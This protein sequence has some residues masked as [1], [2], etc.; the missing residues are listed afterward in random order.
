MEAVQHEEALGVVKDISPVQYRF[1]TEKVDLDPLY[2]PLRDSLS[3]YER[4][5]HTT[6]KL[7]DDLLP[8]DGNVCYSEN[9]IVDIEAIAKKIGIEIIYESPE[10]QKELRNKHAVLRKKR[11]GYQVLV[12]KEAS[13]EEQ[14]F[15]I[16][17]E[18]GHY[19]IKRLVGQSISS[20][21]NRGLSVT[22]KISR[23]ARIR[24]VDDG[25]QDQEIIAAR[26]TSA[27]I[28][29]FFNKGKRF[30]IG[31]FVRNSSFLNSWLLAKVY[32]KL[33]KKPVSIWKIYDTMHKNTE[34]TTKIEKAFR[35][36]LAYV[37]EEEKADYFAANILVPTERFVLWRSKSDNKIAKAFGVPKKC[38]LKRRKYEIKH[39]LD[40]MSREYL[41][42]DVEIEISAPSTPK[43]MKHVLGGHSIHDI[44]RD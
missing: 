27:S 35:K 8:Y 12:N 25:R 32:R 39:E 4:L 42:S 26:V 15:S 6:K 22:R 34:A 24:M 23:P 14:R 10:K 41:S 2:Y 38:I 40:F 5:F 3:F 33:L 28:L 37:T 43:D 11:G 29:S 44:G 13:K 7:V 31:G 18:L 20:H 9:P 1:D 19:L 36:T 30:G 16:A 17:H 21:K